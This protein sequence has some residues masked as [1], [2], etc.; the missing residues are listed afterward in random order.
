MQEKDE[1]IENPV[2]K[3]FKNKQSLENLIKEDITPKQNYS[4]PVQKTTKADGSN[5]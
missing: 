3:H 1:S 4:D 2:K 5:K